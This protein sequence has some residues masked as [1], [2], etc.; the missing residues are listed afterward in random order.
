MNDDMM[1]DPDRA[2]A[3]AMELRWSDQDALGHVNNARIITL[4]EEARIRWMRGGESNKR[5]GFGTVVASL[6]VDYLRPLHYGPDFLIRLG[7]V[8]IGTK[9]FTV[10]LVGMQHGVKVFDGTTV[11]VPLAEDGVSS[12]ALDQDE[13]SWL[14]DSVVSAKA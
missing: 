3:V 14:E 10:R 13:R 9:S 4:M 2:V 1:P 12:R 7:T 11:M 5:F 8:R 6:Q